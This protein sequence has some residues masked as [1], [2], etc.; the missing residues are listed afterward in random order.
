MNSLREK[1]QENLRLGITEPTWVP[2]MHSP[3]Q[4]KRLSAKEREQ[5]PFGSRNQPSQN[6]S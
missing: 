4:T 5:S 6:D 1:R 2:A 3:L